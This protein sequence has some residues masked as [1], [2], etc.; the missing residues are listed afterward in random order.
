MKKYL[1]SIFIIILVVNTTVFSAVLNNLSGKYSCNGYDRQDKFLHST[2]LTFT[3]DSKNSML[4]NGYGAYHLQWPPNVAATGAV[5]TNGNMLAIIF[6]N[7]NPK[8][9]TDYG[10]LIGTATHDQD[11]RGVSHTVLHF[12]GYQPVY[13]G[14]DNSTWIC[15]KI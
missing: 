11:T 6:K 2:A 15:K 5:A 7:T 10:V 4:R 14:G 13:K 1:F 8:A 9:P 3:L 12:F